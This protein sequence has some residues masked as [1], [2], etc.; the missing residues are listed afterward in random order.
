MHRHA[1]QHGIL[2]VALLAALGSAQTGGSVEVVGQFPATAEACVDSPLRLTFDRKI[3]PGSG[4][5]GVYR[6]DG[7]LVESFD[8]GRLGDASPTNPELPQHLIGGGVGASRMPTRYYPLLVADH[9]VSVY[10]DQPLEYAQS[11]YVLVDPGAVTGV[12]GAAFAGIADPTAWRFTTRQHP[13]ASAT[14]GLNV[15]ADGS[16]DFCTLQGAI[17]FVPDEPDGQPELVTVQRGTYTEIDYVN[18]TK[19]PITVHGEDRYGVVI[20]YSNNNTLNPT[21]RTRAVFGADAADFTLENITIR[22]TTQNGCGDAGQPCSRGGQAEAF[23][24]EAERTLLNHATFKS[25]QD[26]L[27]LGSSIR[28]S[29]F[30]NDAYIEGNVDY[31]W[32]YGRAFYQNSELRNLARSDAAGGGRATAYIA[33][34]RNPEGVA[35]NVYV[36]CRL[37]RDPAVEDG[38]TYLARIDPRAGEPPLGFPFSQAIFI[39]TSMQPHIKAE[40]WLL[41]NATDAPFVAFWEYASGPPSER[42]AASHQ[43]DASQ[44]QFWSNPANVLGGWDPRSRIAVSTD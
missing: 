30:V 25:F 4:S 6:Q 19:P 24:N 29:A 2:A 12:Y 7:E 38:T 10:L 34:V 3:T 9:I 44:A 35:G 1:P 8:V 20:E 42:A 16:G 15:A 17:D 31:T 13:P 21:S 33:Q 39:N 41:N 14:S 27:Q 26:T 22:N 11:Y 32:G 43:L 23:R 18:A 40:G 36:N 5:I 28:A 37:T